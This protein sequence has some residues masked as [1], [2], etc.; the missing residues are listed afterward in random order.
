M[1]KTQLS[2]EISS[3]P[4][5]KI[6]LLQNTYVR[7]SLSTLVLNSRDRH[8][9]LW[10]PQNVSSEQPDNKIFLQHAAIKSIGTTLL[11]PLIHSNSL[12]LMCFRIE[13]VE[14]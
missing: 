1:Y 10:L 11:A 2:L 12:K 4:V 6:L 13:V 9:N 8:E 3:L 14:F 7:V 5:E